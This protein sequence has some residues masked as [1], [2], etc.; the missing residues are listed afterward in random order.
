MAKKD[1]GRPTKKDPEVVT[2]L[3]SAFSMGFT[4]KEACA[5][6]GIARETFYRW[7]NDD[8]EFCD[9][10]LQAKAKLNIKA[11]EVLVDAIQSGDVN[12]AK[13]WLAKYDKPDDINGN[14]T[15]QSKILKSIVATKERLIAYRYRNMLF[16]EREQLA[17]D[18]KDAKKLSPQIERI[19]RLIRLSD[20]EISDYAE[21]EISSLNLDK[22][23]VRDDLLDRHDFKSLVKDEINIL[24]KYNY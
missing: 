14:L 20:A 8:L 7:F 2:K 11:K 18:R 10:I 5:Y 15:F 3:T 1:P 17:N 21:L 23:G 6:S 16:R 24:E 9:K 4:I 19:D 12:S 22:A 13:W